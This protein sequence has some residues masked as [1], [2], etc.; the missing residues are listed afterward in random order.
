MGLSW[1]CPKVFAYVVVLLSLISCV[2]YCNGGKTSKFVRNTGGEALDMP[3]NSDVFA[4][5]PGYNSPQQVS[6]LI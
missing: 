1:L 4:L 2:T 6:F 5:P 3:L